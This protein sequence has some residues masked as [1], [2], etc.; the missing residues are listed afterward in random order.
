MASAKRVIPIKVVQSDALDAPESEEV[1]LLR[2]G[3]LRKTVIGE[4]RLSE[5]VANYKA[6][7]Y[8]VRVVLFKTEGDGCNTCF[9]AA[10]EMSQTFGTVYVRKSNAPAPDDE[11][12]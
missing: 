4:P 2:E 5:L 8:D 1:V 3:W 9:D 10:S 12:F 7:G 6:L 11:L